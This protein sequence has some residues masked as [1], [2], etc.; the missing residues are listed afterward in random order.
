MHPYTRSVRA[1]MESA[2]SAIQCKFRFDTRLAATRISSPSGPLARKMVYLLSSYNQVLDLTDSGHLKLYNVVITGL[3]KEQCFDGNKEN[4]RS[5]EKIM[6]EKLD[7]YGLRNIFN[8]PSKWTPG[9]KNPQEKDVVDL[10]ATNW[11]TE[12]QVET[13]S[14]L[15]W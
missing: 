9:N 1:K 10:F 2:I 6:E 4:F 12:L 5:F 7:T 11:L 13:V 15:I 8:I 14:D 3:K